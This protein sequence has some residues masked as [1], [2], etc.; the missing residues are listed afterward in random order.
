MDSVIDTLERLTIEY[1]GLL[2]GGSASTLL[3][4]PQFD[5]HE[6]FSFAWKPRKES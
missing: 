6:Q 5:W 3:P 4:T 2:T 1:N